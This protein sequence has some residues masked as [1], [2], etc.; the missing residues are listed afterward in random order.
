MELPPPPIAAVRLLVASNEIVLGR[1]MH[2]VGRGAEC[3]VFVDDP[4]AS[5]RHA[6][7]DVRADRVIVR[8]L[9][10][11]NGVLLNSAFIE[12]EQLL[13]EGDLLMVGVRSVLIVQID[14]GSSLPPPPMLSAPAS[15]RPVETFTLGPPPYLS[16]PMS[17]DDAIAAAMAVVITLGHSTSGHEAAIPA[18]RVLTEAATRSIAE[19]H[20]P[21]AEAI[22]GRPLAEVLSTQRAGIRVQGPLVEIASYAALD[23]AFATG[24][25]SWIEYVFDLHAAADSA[26]PP[27]ITERVAAAFRKV[28]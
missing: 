19:G 14:H 2:V 12:G 16:G 11:R 17:E 28:T 15:C 6:V 26:I 7:I 8:D 10:S 25:R 1:G 22:L 9:G 13:A 24:E 20:I 3:P 21:R 23:L 5:R 27:A 18:F 4:H